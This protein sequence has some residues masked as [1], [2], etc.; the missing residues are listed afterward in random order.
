MKKL[1]PVSKAILLAV[2]FFFLSGLTCSKAGRFTNP[3]EGLQKS[4]LIGTWETS[5]T[6]RETDQIR[7]RED[8]KCRQIYRDTGENYYF[9]T[10]WKECYLDTFVDGR[11]WLYVERG[12]YYVSGEDFAEGDGSGYFENGLSYPFTDPYNFDADTNMVNRLV[13]TVR[14]DNRG[15]IVFHHLW[16]ST[17]RGF[18]LIGGESEIFRRVEVESLEKDAPDKMKEDR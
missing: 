4:D 18:A 1:A 2:L 3:E 5:Y 16:T 6:P 9:D 11:V 8:G 13:V 15:E 7:I 12:R 10:G 17:D 14:M